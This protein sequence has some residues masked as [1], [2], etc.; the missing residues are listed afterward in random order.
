M[1][2]EIPQGLN[3]VSQDVIYI[4]VGCSSQ[5]G[6]GKVE[7]LGF[8]F[9]LSHNHGCYLNICPETLNGFRPESRASL[10]GWSPLHVMSL[11]ARLK[12][13]PFKTAGK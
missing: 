6:Y 2:V 1:S 7:K 11:S 12:P 8:A 4:D 5:D 3:V 13:C 9:Q 10:R